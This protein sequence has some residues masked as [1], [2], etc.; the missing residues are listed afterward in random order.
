MDFDNDSEMLNF[1]KRFLHLI[2]KFPLTKEEHDEINDLDKKFSN[3]F[4]LLQNHNH[5]HR[6]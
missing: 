2:Y 4:N 5:S 1:L 6:C 3:K